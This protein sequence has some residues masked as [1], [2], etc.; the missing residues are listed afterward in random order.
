MPDTKLNSIEEVCSLGML[1][2]FTI[3]FLHT[4]LKRFNP[5]TEALFF[6]LYL[7]DTCDMLA[8]VLFQQFDWLLSSGYSLPDKNKMDSHFLPVID[9]QMFVLNEAVVSPN[10]KKATKC[11]KIAFFS[12]KAI[13]N[14]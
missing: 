9:K 11:F 8:I 4:H 6:L 2:K 5:D 13:S 14:A 3:S 10:T 12:F 1:S 7:A